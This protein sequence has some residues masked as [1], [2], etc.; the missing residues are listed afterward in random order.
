MK[1]RHSLLTLVLGLTLAGPTAAQ[2]RML[3]ADRTPPS[4]TPASIQ[5]SAAALKA[6]GIRFQA[7][8]NVREERLLGTRSSSQTGAMRPDDRS[9]IHGAGLTF[10]TSA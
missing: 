3:A 6:A 9:G 10:V 2:A 5:T 4:R 1:T 8:K 7:A